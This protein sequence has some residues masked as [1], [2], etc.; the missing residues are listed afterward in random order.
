MTEDQM[1][2]LRCNKCQKDGETQILVGHSW[3]CMKHDPVLTGEGLGCPS[4]A[5]EEDNSVLV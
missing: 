5:H 3:L 4:H 2:L 1:H